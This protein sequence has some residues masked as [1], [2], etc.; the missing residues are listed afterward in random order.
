MILGIQQTKVL[1]T[2]GLS[3]GIDNMIS[4]REFFETFPSAT[5]EDYNTFKKQM[6]DIEQSMWEEDHPLDE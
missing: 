3:K 2:I 4:K 1:A 5:N 6:A